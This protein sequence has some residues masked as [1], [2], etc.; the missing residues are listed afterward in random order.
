MSTEPVAPVAP[1]PPV[2]GGTPPVVT[3]PVPAPPAPAPDNSTIQTLR[4]QI[5][6]ANKRASDA[7]AKARELELKDADELTRT[8]AE[9]GDLKAKVTELEPL[10]G[11]HGKFVSATEAACTAALARIP[12]EKRTAIQTLVQH[13]PLA[14]RLPAITAA[15]D[16]IGVAPIAGGTRTNPGSGL[17]PAPGAPEA[18]QPLKPEEIGKMGWGQAV[19]ATGTPQAYP[20]IGKIVQEEVAKALATVAAAKT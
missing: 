16:A 15:A 7:E 8:K 6:A 11:E 10:R 5:E 2:A 9:L 13:V 3:P 12:E 18:A 20:D 14:E 1:T 4:A 17:P 19:K